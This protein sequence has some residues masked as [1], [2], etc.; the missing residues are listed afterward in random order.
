MVQSFLI[1]S[2]H[3]YTTKCYTSPATCSILCNK[4]YIV[5]PSQ[6]PAVRDSNTKNPFCIKS[7]VA[8]HALNK[9]A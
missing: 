6:C 9:T 7:V 1:N 3:K 4:T 2:Y 8:A 5:R